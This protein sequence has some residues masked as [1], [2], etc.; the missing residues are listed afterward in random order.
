MPR[1]YN[2]RRSAGTHA[3]ALLCLLVVLTFLRAFIPTGYMPDPEALAQGRFVLMPC[4]AAGDTPLQLSRI[5]YLEASRHEGHSAH[6]EHSSH[7]AHAEQPALAAQG[8]FANETHHANH[9]DAGASL[10]CPF[11]LLAH[12]TADLATPIALNGLPLQLAM[13]AAVPLQQSRPPLPAAGPPLGP[14]A[15]PSLQI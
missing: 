4:P 14:R 13:V 3:Y 5:A 12:V 8:A 15:P 7:A 2:A 6:A 9:A 10:D 11:S 1:S